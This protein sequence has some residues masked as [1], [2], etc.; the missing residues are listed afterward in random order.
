MTVCAFIPDPQ[1]GEAE[2]PVL[3]ITDFC[4]LKSVTEI[5]QNSVT[6]RGYVKREAAWKLPLLKGLTLEGFDS[7]FLQRQ[8]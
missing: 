4:L 8:A 1:K 6:K 7:L 2:E 3:Y 5:T